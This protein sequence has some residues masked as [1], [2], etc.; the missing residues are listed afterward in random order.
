MI[1]AVS[2]QCD[3]VEVVSIKR[4][5]LNNTSKTECFND[6]PKCS[7][8]STFIISIYII[9]ATYCSN[10]I[11]I[12]GITFATTHHFQSQLTILWSSLDSC[13]EM[14]VIGLRVRRSR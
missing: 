5:T 3:Y 14:K 13:T 4:D 10:S 1:I 7:S 9:A 11:I 2:G 8:T 6:N 12:V